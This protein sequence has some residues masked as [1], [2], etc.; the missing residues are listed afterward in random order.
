MFIFKTV[1]GV[2]QEKDTGTANEKY[3]FLKLN[4]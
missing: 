4:N 2:N 3:K 1:W